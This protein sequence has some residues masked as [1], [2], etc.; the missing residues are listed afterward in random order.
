LSPGERKR[1]G[2][3]SSTN[4]AGRIC[5]LQELRGEGLIGWKG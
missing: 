5:Q 4:V 3:Q 2:G 1:L